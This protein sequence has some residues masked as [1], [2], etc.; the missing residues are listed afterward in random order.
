MSGSTARGGNGSTGGSQ[1]TVSYSERLYLSW[2]A[3]PVPL[4][5]GASLGATVHLGYPGLRAWLPYVLILL[6]VA[7]ALVLLG[8]T[9]ILLITNGEGGSA[10]PEPVLHVGAARLPARYL[11]D[12][13]VIPR[14]AKRTA[15][16]PEL[17][18][19][20]YVV[21]RGWIGPALRVH[22]TDPADPTPYWLFSTRRP[23]RLAEL[24]RSAAP[25]SP[26]TPSTQ[27]TQD[28]QP[29]EE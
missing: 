10:S 15:L 1:A 12:I 11:G 13:E 23:H 19:A 4:A 25:A 26:A 8:R 9:R 22:L 2:W 18:P 29:A 5:L 27:A 7:A 20:A 21:H 14:G 3:W 17:D 28:G 6:T 16:G 24:L